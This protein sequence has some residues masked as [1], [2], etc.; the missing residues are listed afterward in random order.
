MDG[1]GGAGTQAEAEI[2]TPNGVIGAPGVVK[3]ATP[4]ELPA[5]SAAAAVG[6]TRQ[7]GEFDRFDRFDRG[8]RSHR[9]VT[10]YLACG[11]GYLV[12]SVAMWWHVWSGH[13]ASTATC[14]CGDPALFL[15]FIAWP[16]YA[17]AHG[18][19]PFFATSLFHPSGIDLLS[20]T[21]V[22]AIGVPLAPVTWLFGPVATLNV[23]ATLCPVLNG[24]AAVWL[25]RR[26]VH[27]SPAAFVGGLIFGFSPFVLQSLAYA[28]LMTSDLVVLPFIV[29][30]LD[31]LLAR[32]R[33]PS[34]LIGAVLG[35]LVTV[36]FFVST[37]MLVITA[38]SVIFGV[39]IVSAYQVVVDRRGFVLR[40]RWALPG[41]ALA[42][43]VAGVLLAYPAWDALAGPAHLS[44]SLWPDIP[45]I[46]GD[47]LRDFVATSPVVK[48]SF[49]TLLGGYFGKTFPPGAFIGWGVVGASIAGVLVWR[50]DRR[51]CFFG[52][53]AAFTAALTLGVRHH[54]WVPWELLGSF[55]VLDNV[56][57]ER[58]AAITTLALAL[59]VGLVL[60]H[61]RLLELMG[62]SRQARWTRCTR[63]AI[64]LGAAAAAAA[65]ALVPLA[66]VL[67]PVLPYTT[68]SVVLPEWFA[69]RG[70]HLPSSAVVLAYPAP[71]SGIQS[72]MAW[73]AVD[74]LAYAQA[75]GGGPE[76]A[77]ARAGKERAG[78]EVLSTL[79]FGFGPLPSGTP[80]ELDAVREALRGWGVTA[81][82]VPLQPGLPSILRGRD[83]R[84]AVA[85]LSAALGRSPVYHDAAWVWQTST[86]TTGALLQRSPLRVGAGV[87]A[88]CATRA[89][90]DP[91]QPEVV[92]SCVLG[93][94]RSRAS[95]T[96]AH[97]APPSDPSRE[98][99]A[100]PTAARQ[101]VATVSS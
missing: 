86:G 26:W 25:L 80:A 90:R 13:P 48:R 94:A 73:Q 21:S 9:P 4:P 74:G 3:G 27:W 79:S 23:A 85:L 66:V 101:A 70:Q 33:W 24:L 30:A 97:G 11:A 56:I 83:P 60:D 100:L 40:A 20:N 10:V 88:S 37:E 59:V 35:L 2:G 49:V 76:G 54:Q 15:W 55:P 68:R 89:A 16:A 93:S 53:V 5:T 34:W 39:V 51:L 7:R 1:A 57:E 32:R 91:G 72:A 84:Y 69:R 62:H 96:A 31:E 44:G 41:L 46:G 87:L 43:V 61:L 75:G 99:P 47:S 18:H 52:A 65:A 14:G 29:G 28:H 8:G 6:G 63:R 77:A 64:R 78:F 98:S 38:I 22:L 36:Q 82:V 42:A 50:H 45:V 92:A 17:L 81:V 19:N 71:F 95:V 58:F 12:L 67:L